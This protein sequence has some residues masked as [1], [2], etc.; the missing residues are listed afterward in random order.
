LSTA[1]PSVLL[2][3]DHPTLGRVLG[4]YLRQSGKMEVWSTAQTAEAALESL[5]S[6]GG[7][8]RPDLILVDVSLPGMSGLDLLA[9]LGRRYPEMPCL[10][11]SAS[12]NPGHVRQALANGARGYVAKGDAPAIVDAI[13]RVL[14][15]HV[16]LSDAVRQVMEA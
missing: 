6:A 1:R 8:R 11:L 5:A 2:V 4:R 15:G 3:E 16:Y 12:H 7:D 10:M 14:D 9:E 13:R